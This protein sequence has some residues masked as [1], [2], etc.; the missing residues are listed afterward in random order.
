MSLWRDRLSR[1]LAPLARRV[2]LHPNAITVVALLLNLAAAAALGFAGRDRRLFLVAVVLVAVGGLL[3]AL[4]GIVA[5]EQ[6]LATPFGDFLDHFCDRVSDVALFAGWL[7][8][9]GVRPLIAVSALV[10]I[11]LNGYIGTQVE[12]TFGKRSYE[13]VGRG[14]F[15]LAL[16]AFPLI[17]FA[18]A[19]TS[20]YPTTVESLTLLTAF[21]ALV[22]VAQ[23]FREAIRLTREK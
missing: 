22:G 17:A 8:G 2:P 16:I 21:A 1:W 14:E 4:D 19:G 11:M 6:D 18:L 10:M 5:R 15:V 23:R 12:A 3:D 9:T 13:T 20:Y 7:L